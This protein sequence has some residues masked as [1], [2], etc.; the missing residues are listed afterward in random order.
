MGVEEVFCCG[1]KLGGGS[2]RSLAYEC[3]DGLTGGWDLI[4]NA[5]SG[6]LRSRGLKSRDQSQSPPKYVNCL[7]APRVLNLLLRRR[8]RC[9]EKGLFGRAC[10]RPEF[11]LLQ[12]SHNRRAERGIACYG[13]NRRKQQQ[14]L[15]V[16][17]SSP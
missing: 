7:G 15:S 12:P 8:L 11:F 10:R 3:L 6:C 14:T 4:Q 5:A 13:A 17:S 16:T 2:Q 9:F 1:E